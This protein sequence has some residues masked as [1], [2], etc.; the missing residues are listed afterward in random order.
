MNT[1]KF[2]ESKV[3]SVIDE[4]EI[5]FINELVT[6]VSEEVSGIFDDEFQEQITDISDKLDDSANKAESLEESLESLSSLMKALQKYDFLSNLQA[7]KD[8]Q[9][10][11]ATTIIETKTVFN[12]GKTD[13][14]VFLQKMEEILFKWQEYQ[15]KFSDII[16]QADVVNLKINEFARNFQSQ[17]ENVSTLIFSI[18][19][20]LEK[21]KEESNELRTECITSM[22][23]TIMRQNSEAEQ[24][25]A[26]TIQQK[27]SNHFKISIAFYIIIAILIVVSFFI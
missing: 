13:H 26:E 12:D 5:F 2:D 15:N 18:N 11:L 20:T 25:L 1:T 16:E 27:Q 6:K 9:T 23:E 19:E 10:E 21:V 7:F 17:T 3:K 4:K 14:Q 8:I 24:R 22:L